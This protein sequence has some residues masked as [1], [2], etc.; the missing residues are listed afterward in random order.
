MFS[1]LDTV[2]SLLQRDYVI[3]AGKNLTIPCGDINSQT[4]WTRD[5]GN[6]TNNYNIIIVS[7]ILETNKLWFVVRTIKNSL[8]PGRHLSNDTRHHPRRRR[9]LHLFSS[10]QFFRFRVISRLR[11]S[12]CESSDDARWEQDIKVLWTTWLNLHNF[13]LRPTL[14][15]NYVLCRCGWHVSGESDNNYCRIN[16]GSVE[17]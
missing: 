11:S 8:P 7:G 1:S 9:P 15:I 2:L 13:K 17:K 14:A 4:V 5:G 3:N 6:I 10:S 16:L 12:H